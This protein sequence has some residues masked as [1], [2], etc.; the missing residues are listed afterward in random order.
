MKKFLTIATTFV[1][2]AFISANAMAFPKEGKSYFNFN[3]G[4]AINNPKTNFAGG[5]P[6]V[7]GSLKPMARGFAFDMGL[8]YY[9]LDEIRIALNPVYIPDMRSKESSGKGLLLLEDRQ[10][11]QHYGL[12]TNVYYD[13]L[14]GGKMNPFVL[15]GVGYMRSEM[16]DKI[17]YGGITTVNKDT[18][19]KIAYQGGLGLAYHLSS[20]IDAELGWRMMKMRSRK[21]NSAVPDASAPLAISASTDLGLTHVISMGLRFTF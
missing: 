18:R 5:M 8:G 16:E 3:L 7:S 15:V 19:S 11:M 2:G 4:Y 13:F 10:K 21:N 17:T 20:A 6:P 12:F 1:L 14:L 9:L